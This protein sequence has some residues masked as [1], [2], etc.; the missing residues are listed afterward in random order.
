MVTR[1]LIE[2]LIRARLN[3]VLLVAEASLPESQFKAFRKLTLDQFGNSGL[4]KD[5][6][7]IFGANRK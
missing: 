7:R 3:Q 4:G 2:E 1:E 5:L 6:E